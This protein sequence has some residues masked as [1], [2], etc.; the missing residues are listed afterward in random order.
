MELLWLL[1]LP[2]SSF[3]LWILKSRIA[4]ASLVW[5]IRAKSFEDK[6]Q[7]KAGWV[8]C[9]PHASDAVV[10]RWPQSKN[11]DPD[12][13]F[14][15]GCLSEPWGQGTDFE[16]FFEYLER[17]AKSEKHSLTA[18]REEGHGRVNI[19]T[20]IKVLTLLTPVTGSSTAV[21]YSGCAR[22]VSLS[23]F[24]QDSQLNLGSYL[25]KSPSPSNSHP[26]WDLNVSLY[27]CPIGHDPGNSKSSCFSSQRRGAGFTLW[28]HDPG[29]W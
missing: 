12:Q 20:F 14:S 2:W 18:E 5:V 28:Q 22:H 21:Q 6:E 10:W 13:K 27:Q 1:L 29:A 9:G 7:R 15:T 3:L 19:F 8:S 25:L 16:R 17:I 4:R 24:P 23:S 11:H 26:S